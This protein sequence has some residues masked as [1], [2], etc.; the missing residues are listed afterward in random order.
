MNSLIICS[1]PGFTFDEEKV[2]QNLKD[3]PGV[4]NLERGDFVGAVLQCEYVFN[5]DRTIVRLSDDLESI[6]ISGTGE[7]S[8]QMAI[9]L[10]HRETQPLYVTDFGYDF[11]IPLKQVHTIG[12]FQEMGRA[13]G[14]IGAVSIPA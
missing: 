5:S 6:T 11:N 14:N 2:L 7:A 10:Q 3:I 8:V 1:D 4:F 9:E 13:F 12:D